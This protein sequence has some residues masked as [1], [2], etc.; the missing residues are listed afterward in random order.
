[1]SERPGAVVAHGE[2]G[3]CDVVVHGFLCLSKYSCIILW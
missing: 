1:L 3:L 2:H